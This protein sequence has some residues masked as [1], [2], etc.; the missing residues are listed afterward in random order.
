MVEREGEAFEN[1]KT[2]CAIPG[3]GFVHP[4]DELILEL[5]HQ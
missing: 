4:I 5:S 1:L 2:I 3:A